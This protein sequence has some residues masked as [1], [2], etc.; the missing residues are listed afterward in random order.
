MVDDRNSFSGF[1]TVIAREKIACNELNILADI[2]PTE[3]FLKTVKP[4]RGPNETAEIAEAIFEKGLDDA[5]TDKPVRPRD[6]N[7]ITWLN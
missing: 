7:E 1:P 3:R 6:Q 4:A 2:K 5:Y